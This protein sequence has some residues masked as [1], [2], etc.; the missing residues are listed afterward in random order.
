MPTP[1]TRRTLEKHVGEPAYYGRKL[2]IQGTL[3]REEGGKRRFFVVEAEA[4]E[5]RHYVKVG[6]VISLVGRYAVSKP[7]G[8]REMRHQFRDFEYRG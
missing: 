5:R 7:G 1:I 8:G 6:D 3:H 2:D 4:L